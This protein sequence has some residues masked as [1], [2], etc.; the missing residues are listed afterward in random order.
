MARALAGGA[1]ERDNHAYTA[2]YPAVFR[3]F[4]YMARARFLRQTDVKP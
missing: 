4:I 2:I 3:S 1:G